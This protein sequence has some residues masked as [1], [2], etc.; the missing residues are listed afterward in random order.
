MISRS[1]SAL[2]SSVLIL[3]RAYAAIHAVSAR[4]AFCLLCKG[5][6]E[7]VSIEDGH[8]MTYNFSDWCE[9]SELRLSL[10]EYDE[11][12][13]WVCSVNFRVQ[14]PRII[15][16]L[17]YDR[18]PRNMV[19]FSRRNVFLRD[20]HR[21]QYCR[22][23]FG[24]QQLSLDHVLPRSRGGGMTW[25]NIVCACLKCNVRKGGRTP[26]EAGMQLFRKPF[27]PQRSPFLSHQLQTEKY[28]EWQ[29]FLR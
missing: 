11:T 16:L 17:T 19:K 9:I 26:Q 3:N 10:N 15:R 18:V 7:V 25:D 14:V 1:S 2:E 29:P 13:E 22:K 12:E 23:H 6:A 8:Y 27:R 20:E 28:A 24:T 5:V 4:R 21:C